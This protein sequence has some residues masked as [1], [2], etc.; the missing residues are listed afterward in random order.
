M[1]TLMLSLVGYSLNRKAPIKQVDIIKYLCECILS[2]NDFLLKTVDEYISTKKSKKDENTYNPDIIR[3]EPFAVDSKR[4]QY[5]VL[6]SE[7]CF[8]YR[9]TD[10]LSSKSKWELAATDIS[11]YQA[12]SEELRRTRK[13]EN[14]L[15]AGSIDKDIIPKIERFIKRRE[16]R[17]KAFRR[18]LDLL[19]NVEIR[20]TRTR[21]RKQVNYN[22]DDQFFDDDD[23]YVY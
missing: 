16:K 10:P 17:E 1:N 8:M 12:I 19:A 7:T 21:K 15:I 6:G 9:E 18:N 5:W 11:E 23:A 22:M 13:K 3:L 14:K 4:R 2:S 20:E